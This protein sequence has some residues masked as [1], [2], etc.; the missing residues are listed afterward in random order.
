MR[1]L[2]VSSFVLLLACVVCGAAF[3]ADRPQKNVLMLHSF[4]RDFKPWSE[5]AKVVRNELNRQSPWPVNIIE[6][7]LLSALHGDENPEGSFVGYLRALFAR[8][9]PDIVLSMGAP[10]AGF[11]QRHRQQ[12][13][14]N[15][16]MVF[17][18]VEQR[19]VQRSILTEN[20]T[21][22]A[23]AH[24]FPAIVDNILRILPDTKTIAMVIGA[25]PNERFWLGEMR[26]ELAPYTHRVSFEWYNDRAFPEILKQAAES[27]AHMAIYWHSL[28]VDAAGVVHES[29]TS[30]SKL[31]AVANAPIFTFDGS[32]F[33]QEIVGG[34]M[35]S[36]LKLGQATAA[37]VVRILGG[38][39]AGDITTPASGFAPPIY[40]WRQLQRWG[41]SETRLP[42]GSEIRFREPTIWQRH[43]WTM[44]AIFAA[45][46]VQSALIIALFWE[47]R[48][49][50]RSEANA[51][52]LMGGLAHTNRIAT[53]GQLTASIAHEIRQPL[54][55]IAS[56]SSA[57]L[58]WLKRQPPNVEE[59]RSGLENIINQVHRVDDVI[60]NVNA[61]FKNESTA[62]TEV[63]LNTL[64][65]QVLTS[66]AR[67]VVSNGIVRET[68]LADNPPPYV[69]ANPGQ[70]Q[71][72]I[73]NLITNAIEAMSAS[74]HGART[75]RI[76]TSIDQADSV[77][78]TVADSG[79]GFDSKVAEELFK[80][81]FTTKS[82]GMGLG[83]PI[84]KSVIEAHNG[85][86]TVASREPRGAVFRIVLPRARHE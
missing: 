7:S 72:V 50:R 55:S 77:V 8:E 44:V 4:G 28:N 20:D 26:R 83:L 29:E 57:G 65:R 40:D 1:R 22:V 49:R 11:V 13:F 25:S 86:L 14:A 31:Y 16:P 37:V 41:I 68:K 34:P 15:T 5:Y 38:E 76:E 24:D 19:R 81:F 18:A 12:L 48:R 84:C 64:V 2:T 74:E 43:F 52:V 61:L 53:A 85:K 54:A 42:P 63:N 33:G 59:V 60:K 21:V 10:A 58:N 30:L 36:V 67:A 23:V 17:T 51:Q 75:L 78:I 32:F 79:P 70:L 6:H 46:A 62:R 80:P 66:T 71:Q 73:L 3:A 39:K 45:L 47:D 27:P 35:H 69:M 9:P 56:F 82:S